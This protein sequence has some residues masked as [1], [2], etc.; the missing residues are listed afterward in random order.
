MQAGDKVRHGH[1]DEAGGGDG[2]HIGDE[3]PGPCLRNAVGREPT[4][5]PWWRPRGPRAAA[6]GRADSPPTAAP[7]CPPPAGDL[8]GDDGDGQHDTQMDAGEEGGAQQHAVQEVM[9]AG[10]DQDH[11][12]GRVLAQIVVSSRGLQWPWCQNASFSSRKNPSTPRA[13]ARPTPCTWLGPGAVDGFRQQVQEGR[14]QERAHGETHQPRQQ[15]AA[16][17]APGTTATPRPA[18]RSARA[19]RSVAGMIQRDARAF[20]SLA[21]ASVFKTGQSGTG[22]S[23]SAILADSS[24]LHSQRTRGGFC[25]VQCRAPSRLPL[26]NPQGNIP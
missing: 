20:E 23:R 13:S 26:G 10:A 17:A 22:R 25:S 7:R 18:A 11:G 6:P 14:A 9:Q 1:V 19:P 5:P 24:A 2:Q 15:R 21:I 8:V 12:A 16:R 4:Q 3:A